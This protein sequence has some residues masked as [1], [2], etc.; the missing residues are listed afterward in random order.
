MLETTKQSHAF[1][2]RT[3]DVFLI[4]TGMP[5]HAEQ[6]LEEIRHLGIFPDDIRAILLTHHDVDH[7]GNAQVLQ[8]ATGAELWAPLEDMP[9]IIGVKKRPGVKHLIETIVRPPIPT[10]TGIYGKH[11]PYADIRVMCAPGHTPGHTI[12]QI[13]NVVFTGDLFKFKKGR[14]RIFP[15]YMNWDSTQSIHSLSLLNTLTFEWLCPSHGDPVCNGPKLRD[16]LKKVTGNLNM[17]NYV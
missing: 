13:R 15:G 7:I 10:V 1:L 14:F 9:Y 8:K 12:F 5:G 2:V 17:Q 4:D 16:F 6:I 3:G 11:W